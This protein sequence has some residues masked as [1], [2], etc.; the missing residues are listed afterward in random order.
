MDVIKRAALVAQAVEAARTDAEAKRVRGTVE[1]QFYILA[2]D[3]A[4]TVGVAN[5]AVYTEFG[6]IMAAGR[7]QIVNE[8]SDEQADEYFRDGHT[9]TERLALSADGKLP[10]AVED[11]HSALESF[12]TYTARAKRVLKAYLAGAE[13]RPDFHAYLTQWRENVKA[14]SGTL[15]ALA[16][17][18]KEETAPSVAGAGTGG[19]GGSEAPDGGTDTPTADTLETILA[20]L[21]NLRERAMRLSDFEFAQFAAAVADMVTA[22]REPVELEEQAA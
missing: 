2:L 17:D 21:A 15:W 20:S 1:R 14:P 11:A 4:D 22:T 5:A 12:Y 7:E 8:L 18:T 3:V 6:L 9:R 10:D 13:E 19:D 16:G